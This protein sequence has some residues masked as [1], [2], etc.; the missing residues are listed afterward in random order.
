MNS[1]PVASHQISTLSKIGYGILL[2][3]I[4]FVAYQYI[5]INSTSGSGSWDGMTIFF[6]SL[7]IVPGLLV[8]NCWVTPIQWRRKSSIFVAGLM[9]PA[10]I[11]AISFL[12]LYGPDK[13]RWA[14]KSIKAAPP[15]EVWLFILLF[16]APLLISVIYAIRR[17]FHGDKK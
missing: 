3:N 9:I 16:F 5:L 7:F 15:L 1:E 6:G 11:G 13:I 12:W 17:R 2:P 8:A 10:V 14:I 4:I